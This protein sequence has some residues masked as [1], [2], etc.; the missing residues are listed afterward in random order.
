MGPN[1]QRVSRDDIAKARGGADFSAHR[2][3]SEAPK[4]S[5]HASNKNLPYVARFKDAEIV[6]FFKKFGYLSHE[7]FESQ[8]GTNLVRVNCAS[9]DV[10]FSDFDMAVN[11]YPES[12]VQSSDFDFDSFMAYC[13]SNDL[14]PEQTIADII[15]TDLFDAKFPSYAEARQAHKDAAA[16]DSYAALPKTMR[17]LLKS[18]QE[19]LLAVNKLEGN[20]GK[21]GYFDADRFK[22]TGEN[23]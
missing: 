2:Y 9:F 8:S 18:A 13:T 7:R 4:S 11:F 15:Y 23:A 22:G 12:K 14:A 10:I 21:Y 19:K 3:S 6:N 20:K 5:S 1:I 16:H 17:P